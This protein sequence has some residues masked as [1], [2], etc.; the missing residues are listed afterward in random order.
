M[1]EP[2]VNHMLRQACMAEFA[3]M[4]ILNGDEGEA[5]KDLLWAF[6]QIASDAQQ[7]ANF[8]KRS[9]T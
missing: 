2:M 5:A 3:A 6:R 9:K 4:T 7:V 1:M 8:Y